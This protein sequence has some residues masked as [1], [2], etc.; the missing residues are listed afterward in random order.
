MESLNQTSIKGL[1]L[2]LLFF[3]QFSLFAQSDA[4]SKLKVSAFLES[5]YSYDFSQPDGGQRPSFLFNYNR[6]NEFAPNLALVQ[7]DYEEERVR[8]RISLMAGTYANANLAEEP[9]VLRNIF[10]AYTGYKLSEDKNVWLDVGIF[11]SHLGF[12]SAVGSRNINLSRSLAAESSP[13]YL[14]GA[15]ITFISEDESLLLSGIMTNGWQRIQRE[16]GNEI[17]AGGHHILWKPSDKISLNSSSYIGGGIGFPN[18]QPR[19]GNGTFG[20]RYFHNFYA[21][22]D[23]SEIISV[24]AG[25][26][27]GVQEIP[28]QSNEKNFASWNVFTVVAQAR[29]NEKLRTGLRY[30]LLDDP[31]QI[32]VFMDDFP[33]SLQGYSLN[34]DYN[35]S[36]NLLFRM[37]GRYFRSSQQVFENSEKSNF[38]L[39]A[40]MALTF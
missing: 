12:E 14:S 1:F 33:I 13:Y 17:F 8:G 25:W 38:A 34:V 20:M 28:D 21:Q 37:E 19:V 31:D 26:D 36:S 22:I 2:A 5:Y 32:V 9:G 30:E 6:H 27:Y 24:I 16:E 7:L 40:S 15:K 4:A 29:V 18:T 11:E 3:C 10:E 39:T 23:V 35:L